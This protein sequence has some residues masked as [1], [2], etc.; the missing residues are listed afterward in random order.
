MFMSW[1]F[2]INHALVTLP[3]GYATALLDPAVGAVGTG[4]LMLCSMLSSLFLGSLAVATLT[5]KG[6]LV[7]A[8]SALTLCLAIFAHSTWM[9]DGSALQW[10]E[11]L[12]SAVLGGCGFGIGWTAQGTFFARTCARLVATEGKLLEVVTAQLSGNFARVLLAT[13]FVVRVMASALRGKF[14]EFRFSRPLMGFGAEFIIF[15]LISLLM[16]AAMHF[17]VHDPPAPPGADGEA[18]PLIGSKAMA[19]MELWRSPAIWFLSFT[20]LSFGFSAGYMNGFVNGFLAKP[21]QT[22]GQDT[23]GTLMAVTCLVAALASLVFGSKACMLE[24]RILIGVGAACFV[25]IPL[26]VLIFPPDEGNGYWGV[27][28]VLLYFL[29]GTGRAVYEST[30][31]AQF[32]DFFPGPQSAGA[33]ANCIMQSAFANSLAYL[34]QCTVS[35]RNLSSLG[36]MTIATAAL[37]LPGT[38]AADYFRK[39]AENI[40]RE[41]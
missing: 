12:A 26:T 22:F 18:N 25:A 10:I 11:Y 38:F 27:W 41:V 17:L 3:I 4:V 20:N 21:S 29:Q 14:L 7:A 13:E 6:A 40:Q 8:M 39:K 19:A 31:R 5:P 2:N 1:A 24:K 9:V 28:L 16:V 32:A 33:F 37:T 23:L 30:N 34:L 36:W 35:N 15:S